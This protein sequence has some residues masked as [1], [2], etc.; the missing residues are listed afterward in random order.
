MA[1]GLD[2]HTRADRNDSRLPGR[3][4][5]YRVSPAG[6]SALLVRFADAIAKPASALVHEALAALDGARPPGWLDLM[7]GY[8]SLLIVYDPVQLSFDD[9]TATVVAIINESVLPEAPEPP[10]KSAGSGRVIEIPVVY[11]PDVAPD[12]TALAV[13]KHLTVDRLI[14]LHTAPLYRCQMLGFRPGFPFLMGLDPQLATP[15]LSTPRLSVPA[16]SVG[17][18]GAQTGI[19]PSAGPGGWRIVGRTTAR[20][21]DRARA[22]SVATAGSAFLIHPGDQIRF[23]PSDP[24]AAS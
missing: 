2:A 18:G 12:L 10:A 15:R 22:Q 4:D 6:D 5:W 17:R 14:A 24:P 13:E 23:V 16:G 19:Y 3:P 8:A 9:V 7:P 11:H 20:L 1:I 21:F